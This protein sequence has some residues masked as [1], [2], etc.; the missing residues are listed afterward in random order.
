MMRE[1]IR[2]AIRIL[3]M[4]ISVA[5]ASERLKE[6]KA[7]V[8]APLS[9]KLAEKGLKLGDQI[10]LRAFKQNQELEVWIKPA[11]KS[12]YVLFRAYQVAGSSGGLGPKL[13]EGD[14]QMPEG[15]YQITKGALNPNSRYHLSFNIGYPN[16]Y[17]RSHKRTGSFI[18][19][20]GSNVSIGCYAMTDPGIEEIYLITEAA[21][22]NG[23]KTVSFH[24]YPFRFDRGWKKSADRNERWGR[25]W[26]EELYPAYRYFEE[27]R[28][29][30]SISH[31]KGKYIMR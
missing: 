27:K 30:A 24:S 25:F 21:L 7:R 16:A 19:V 9:D 31:S 10:F 15:F 11:G 5:T 8:T 4:C 18:M 2:G 3:I 26:A 6:V 14:G 23:Q 1:F 12:Q 17:D 22:K 13:A 28:V 20:H 29:P